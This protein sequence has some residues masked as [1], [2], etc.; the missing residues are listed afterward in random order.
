MPLDSNSKSGRILELYR[1]FL[2]GKVINKQEMA[3]Y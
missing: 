1:M 2:M 3:D